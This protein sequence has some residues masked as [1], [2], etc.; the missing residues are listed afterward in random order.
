MV[1]RAPDITERPLIDLTGRTSVYYDP[2]GNKFD[3]AIASMPFIMAA[4]DNT[5]YRR[6]T[7][8]FRT[9]RVDQARDPGE[10]T[11]S[12]SGYW[13]RSQS[14][15]HLG[16]GINY[17]EPIDGNADEVRFRYKSSSGI[18]PWTPGELSLLKSTTL[19]EAFTGKVY[20]FSQS[21]NGTEY[22]VAITQN[23]TE[24]K[25]IIQYTT[26]GVG[27][28]I[29]NNT[30]ITEKIIAAG[31]GGNDLFVVT[32][33]KVYRYSFDAATPA[34]HLDYN[35][36]SA[37]AVEATVNYVKNRFIIAYNDVNG[38]TFVYEIT[39]QTGSA[40]NF[41]TLTAVN[42]SSTLP[43]GF[44]FRAITESSAAIYIGGFSGNQ[45]IVFKLT[46]DST[47]TLSTMTSVLVLPVGERLL[48][49]F[50]YLGTYVMIG[51][52]Y[53]VRVAVA[54][55]T[56]DLSYGPLVFESTYGIYK[57]A[58]AGTFVWAGVQTAIGG[59]S[60]TYRINLGS[61]L[62]NGS[63]ASATDL[64]STG[65]GHVHGMAHFANR[66]AFTVED[67]G[68][69][70]EHATNLVETGEIVLAKIRFDTLENKAW[71]RIRVRTPATLAGDIDMFKVGPT[72][73][74]F[75]QSINEGA[76]T[77]YDYDLATVFTDTAVDASFTFTLNRNSTSATTGAVINGISVKAL[78]TPTRARVLQ[79][80]LFL[81]DKETDKLGNIVGYEGYA[82][83][84]LQELETLEAQGDTVIIQDFT[85]G[86]EPTEAVIEQVTFTRTTP[87]ARNYSGFGGIVQVIARTVV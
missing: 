68:V 21:K 72:S 63:Y 11:L 82:R 74:I 19:V 27:T 46:V 16:S 7:A 53:G 1:T 33:T 29:A 32:P 47:G 9:Q 55:D 64:A 13:I 28:T 14:S 69:Y 77:N 43:I 12:G 84:R 4:T 52:N 34:L 81:Y 57:F 71:K 51:T 66:L 8:E 78:P 40:V 22:V 24:T 38:S 44:T 48:G 49:L 59:Y 36:N 56:G 65:T 37:N 70:F 3:I 87:S 85:N 23:A 30:A 41:S 75:I 50:G 79:I 18:N 10:Q 61:P 26:A 31:M 6:Q 20:L 54:N 2:T 83:S 15:F 60:G 58:A 62:T 76:A 45:G 17:A 73:N 5:P 42:G 86:G 80:P 39:R 25:R 35:I 67:S